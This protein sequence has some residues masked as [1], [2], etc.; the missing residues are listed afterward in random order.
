MIKDPSLILSKK[1]PLWLLCSLSLV[2][3]SCFNSTKKNNQTTNEREIP[4]SLPF[5]DASFVQTYV[6][7]DGKLW[8]WYKDRCESNNNKENTTYPLQIGNDT[9]WVSV[10]CG[11]MHSLGIKSDSTLWA[12]GD[13]SHQQLGISNQVTQPC[14]VQV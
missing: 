7:R 2:V 10:S 9:N 3:N 14:P 1:C 4:L 6:I 13:N 5:I 11:I 8:A 12:W